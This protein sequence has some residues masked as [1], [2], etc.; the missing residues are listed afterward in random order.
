MTKILIVFFILINL[1]GFIL[2][3]IDKFRAKRN[4]WRIPEKHLFLVALLFGSIGILTGMYVFHHKTRHLTFTIGIPVILIA[5]LTLFAFLHSWH[6]ER[7]GSPSSAVENELSLIQKLDPDTIQS[8]VSY[9]NL[10]N[11]HLAAGTIDDDP[12][13]AVALFFKHFTYYITS[14][15][16]EGRQAT[17]SVNITNIDTHALAQD[18]CEK[19]LTESVTVFPESAASDTTGDYYRLLKDTLSENTYELVMT[20]AYF[21]LEKGENGW[22]ILSDS[23]L[24]D[25]LVSGF[26]SYLNDPKILSASRVLNIQL[27]ALKKLSADQWMEYLSIEDVFATY[28]TDYYQQ[29]DQ[30]YIRQLA[31]AFDYEILRC[32]EKDD[33]AVAV[34][35]ITSV[36]MTN[37]LTIYKKHLLEYASTT[38]SIRDDDVTFSNKT[39]S[40]LL[41]S[42]QEN[43]Q[44]ASTD[45]DLTFTNNSTTWNVLF[46]EAFSN[47]VMGDMDGA[48]DTFNSLT[49]ESFQN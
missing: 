13:E 36:D 19:I 27:E 41:Q 46:D 7:M 43:T 37:V 18:L 5:Q 4:R 49:R 38:K 44:T 45:V 42:L 8:F 30:E 14:E 10:M 12:A 3:G 33:T 16:T 40:L 26:I 39:A 23:Q 21:H 11:S 35:R 1:A 9:E 31:D 15:E 29:I 28:N 48:I 20:T 25:E 32:S 22:T 34:V 17:V 2:M 6:N 24:E 47:A